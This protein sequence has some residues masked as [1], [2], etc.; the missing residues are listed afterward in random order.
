MVLASMCVSMMCVYVRVSMMCGSRRLSSWIKWLRVR[1]V[2][3]EG[4]AQAIDKDTTTTRF[5]SSATP[6]NNNVVE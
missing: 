2:I 1:A 3:L 4:H 5:S 6:K